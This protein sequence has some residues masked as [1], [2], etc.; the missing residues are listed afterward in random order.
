MEF[1][2]HRNSVVPRM[3]V[4]AC[5]ICAVVFLGLQLGGEAMTWEQSARWG[6]YSPD[7]LWKGAPW[8][9]ITSVFVHFEIWHIAFNLY[10]LWIFGNALEDAIGPWKWLAFFLGAAWVSSALQL[11]LSGDAGVGMSGVGYALFGF[12]WVARRKIPEFARL[13]D[14][15]T[16]A[17]FVIWLVGCAI[18]TQLGWANIGNAAHGAG[19][20]FGATVAAIW[21][22]PA[23]KLL[24]AA[25]LVAL[26]ALSLAPL[27]WCPLSSTWTSLQAFEAHQKSD[28][29][30]AIGWY[31]RS[32]ARGG[33][34]SWA[35]SNLAMIYAEQGN[36][37]GYAGALAEL[38]KIDENAAQ[39][40]EAGYGS[41]L[42]GK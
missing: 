12:G 3:T 9:L 40:I 7:A 39:E 33:D 24:G 42:G 36:A 26:V 37:K 20:L 18:A 25:G 13:L 17:T 41:S 38:R 32:I 4:V 1:L 8:A 6:Y 31:R 22:L 19:L 29:A 23:R 27:V 2:F 14:D 21:M 30:T 10:W 15:R 28:Y 35:L 34:E 5:V 16:I 11:L